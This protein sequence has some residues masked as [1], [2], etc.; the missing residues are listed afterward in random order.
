MT[1]GEDPER[2]FIARRI[3]LLDRLVGEGAL[4]ESAERWLTYWETEAGSRRLDARELSFW[5]E[6]YGWIT[7]GRRGEH[8]SVL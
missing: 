5:D 1:G 3:A 2:V 4:A 7:A 8:P 6:A